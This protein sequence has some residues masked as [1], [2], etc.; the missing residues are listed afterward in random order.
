VKLKQK[1][2]KV[3][4]LQLN[5]NKDITFFFQMEN[6]TP[7]LQIELQSK[8]AQI[9]TYL[10]KTTNTILKNFV[11]SI[12]HKKMHLFIQGSVWCVVLNNSKKD[13]VITI[14]ET[15]LKNSINLCLKINNY[16]CSVDALSINPIKEHSNAFFVAQK[17][18]MKNFIRVL[19]TSSVSKT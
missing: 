5:S 2:Y 11:N 10:F 14:L 4:K 19:A 18:K 15:I 3:N 13:L 17:T 9:D 7:E 12:G 16:I 8:F 1:F 6:P